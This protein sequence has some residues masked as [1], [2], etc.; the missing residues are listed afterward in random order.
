MKSHVISR[1]SNSSF[2]CK[3]GLIQM[4]FL[5]VAITALFM[6][7]SCNTNNTD[8]D[9]TVDNAMNVNE[10]KAEDS[11]L[12]VQTSDADFIVK[13]ANGGVSEVSMAKVA[14]EK[15]M[16]KDVKTFADKMIKDHSKLNNQL[17]KLA[18]SLNITL[19]AAIDENE[20]NHLNKLKST[21][22]ADFDKTYIDMMVNAHNSDV[23]LFE[24]AAKDILVPGIHSFI[25]EALPVLKAHQKA[26][27]F[28]DNAK[29]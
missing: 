19:P 22:G 10:Q 18:D 16:D 8:P 23:K 4:V 29:D 21:A 7:M 12:T 2:S 17:K 9:D 26:I 15:A 25:L 24:R 13:A 11:A 14:K 5:S 20:Q 28:L 3:N 1:K 6:F 27:E